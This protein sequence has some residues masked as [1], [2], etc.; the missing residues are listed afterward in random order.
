[1]KRTGKFYFR[2]EKEVLKSLGL[3]PTPQ[4][5]AGQVAKEEGENEIILAQLKSTDQ[6]SYRIRIEDIN[7]LEY[8]A[9]VS[10]KLPIFLIQFLKS[11]R[12]YALVNLEDIPEISKAL[13]FGTPKEKELIGNLVEE[14]VEVKKIKSSS[15]AREDFYKEKEKRYVKRK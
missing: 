8:H 11:N 7:Q 9:I 3:T 10:N 4:S 15:S 13:T 14:K 1:M 12:M 2:N 5:G 6:G